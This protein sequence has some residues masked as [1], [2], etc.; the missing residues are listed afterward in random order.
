MPEGIFLGVNLVGNWFKLEILLRVKELT[1]RNSENIF[2]DFCSHHHTTT[3]AKHNHRLL[4]GG[5]A[6]QHAVQNLQ[7]LLIWS[8]L[9][10]LLAMMSSSRSKANA[11]LDDIKNRDKSSRTM[12]PWPVA[13]LFKLYSFHVFGASIFVH[14]F[15]GKTWSR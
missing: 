12:M 10:N 8:A 4:N 7:S 3:S 6:G 15:E 13:C 14:D 2:L 1:F 9:V 11:Q 5:R